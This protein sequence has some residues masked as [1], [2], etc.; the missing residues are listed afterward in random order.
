MIVAGTPATPL[1]M[2][3][4]DEVAQDLLDLAWWEW[5]HARLRAGMQISARCL[6]RNLWPNIVVSTLIVPCLCLIAPRGACLM[7][8]AALFPMSQTKDKRDYDDPN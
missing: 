7:R 3:F 4:S 5:D 1:R 6:Q 2:R 8:R